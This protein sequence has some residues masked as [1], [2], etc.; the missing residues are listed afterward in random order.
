M[1]SKIRGG[2]VRL[3][4]RRPYIRNYL[5]PLF[6]GRLEAAP[7]GTVIRGRFRVHPAVL[8]FLVVWFGFVTVIASGFLFSA[9]SWI[10]LL[11]V[12]LAAGVLWF[13]RRFGRAERQ[14]IVDLIQH[15]LEASTDQR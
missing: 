14:V 5:A 6:Y 15:T 12:V 7:G 10:P 1:L 11:M 9:G 2:H 3:R 4:V 8:G 13:L